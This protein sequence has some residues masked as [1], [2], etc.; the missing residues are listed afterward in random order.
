MTTK[1]KSSL[2][3]SGMI[4][5]IVLALKLI[6]KLRFPSSSSLIVIKICCKNQEK[7]YL[8]VSLMEFVE[9]LARPQS[10]ILLQFLRYIL[11]TFGI[12]MSQGSSLWTI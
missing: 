2:L 1:N 4:F 3:S 7:I 10:H 9:Y 6:V 5:V 12:V 8:P 11:N